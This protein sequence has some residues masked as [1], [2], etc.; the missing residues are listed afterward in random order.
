MGLVRREGVEGSV[1]PTFDV[2]G[3]EEPRQV[4]HVVGAE[5]S[6]GGPEVLLDVRHALG[7]GDRHDVVRL[8][9]QPGEG[10]LARGALP[11]RA[12]LSE[13]V[14]Q[15][16]V[17]LE[18]LALEFGHGGTEVLDPERGAARNGPPA[19]AALPAP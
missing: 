10:H 4:R 15:S 11:F 2:S 14:D 16:H 6:R 19:C 9:Q 7:A 13:R 12:E 5:R 18:V 1:T 17:L 3:I 8:G